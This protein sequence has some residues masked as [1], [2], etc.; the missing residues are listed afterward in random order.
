MEVVHRVC[1]DDKKIDKSGMN[2]FL[3]EDRGK[4]IV[5]IKKNED[6]LINKIKN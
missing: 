3:E 2:L 1:S 5:I 4:D 6:V